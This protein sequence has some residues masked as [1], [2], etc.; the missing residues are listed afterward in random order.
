MP[1]NWI[2]LILALL[3]LIAAANA[4][5]LA[6]TDL[7]D[8]L[9]SWAP[10]VLD[11]IAGAGCPH[12]FNDGEARHCAW[13]G[14]LD[15]KAAAGGASFSQDWQAYRE[16]WVV[17]PGDELQWP[18]EVSIDGKPAAVLSRED[19]P[20]IKLA[21]GAHHITGRFQWKEM[22]ESLAL[23]ASIGLVRLDLN[24]RP[25]AQ[26]V[27]D[28]SNR[29]WLQRKQDAEGVEQAQ[30]RV[31]RKLID[32][33]PLML[34]TRISLEVSGKGRELTIDRALLPDLIPKELSSPLPA[35][36]AQDGNLKVQARAGAWELVLV[37]R[38]P[39]PVKT[40]ALP[41]SPGLAA[42]EEIWAFE[43]APLVRSVVIEGVPSVDPQQTTMPQEWRRLPAY[44][45]R[46]G[47]VLGLK[48]VRRGDSDPAPDKLTLERRLWLSF[49][50]DTLTMHDRMQ[51]EMHR[52]TRLTMNQAAQL[53]RVDVAGQDQLITRGSDGLAGI[54]VKRGK[55]NLSADSLAPG[56][57]RSFPAVGW[58]HDFDRMSMQLALPAGWRLLHAGGAD[59][60]DGAWLSRWNLLDFFL[61][62][63]IALA[64]SQL[65]SSGWGLIALAALVL[66]FQEPDAPRYAWLMPLAAVALLRVL[67]AGRF[68]TAVIWIGRI[69]MVA[70]LLIT[71][72]F[73]TAQIRGALYPVLEH[74]E[75]VNMESHVASAE[76]AAAVA[77]APTPA[78]APLARIVPEPAEAKARMKLSKS[79]E[80]SSLQSRYRSVD[81][82]AKVQTGP[83]LP[84]WRW[85]EYRL[86]WDGP[87][88]QDQQLDLWLISPGANKILV[89][90]RLAL[91]ALLLAHLAGM[92]LRPV[93]RGK[94]LRRLGK[95][96]AVL[97]LALSAALNPGSADAQ[98][99]DEKLLAEL[100][101][102]LLRPADCLPECAEISWLSVQ[103]AGSVLR[104][105]LEVDAAIDT[106]LPLP[107]GAKQWAPREARLDG[108]TAYVHRDEQG[109][110]WL[111]APAGKHRI[112]LNGELPA[113]DTLQLPLPRKPRRVEISAADWDVAG[114]SDDAAV[115]DT[116]QL[117][118]RL[119]AGAGSDAPA[120]PPFLRIERRLVLDLVWRVETTVRRDSPLGTP[121]LA[122]IPLLPGE[123]VTTPGIVVKE[124][125]VLINLAPQADSLS[126]SSTLKQ[127]SEIV[128]AAAR[129][130][131]WAESWILAAST[132]WHVSAE[133]LPSVAPDANQEA[134]LV[135]LP[136]PGETLKLKIERPQAVAGQT[137]TI[138]N[139]TLAARPGARV[140]EYQ[141][142]LVLRSSRGLDHNIT[143]P[144]GAIL[145]SVSINGQPRPIRANG[146]QVTLP[147]A[148]GKQSIE[149]VW[150][151]DQGMASSYSTLPAGL[152]L[153]SVNSRID[154]HVPRDRWLLLTSGPG[155]GPA[156]LF[157]G[158]LLIMLA[159]AF[160]LGR[161]AG[162]RLK[163]PHWLLLALGLT[164]VEW[165]ATVLVVGWFFALTMRGK[166]GN[167]DTPRWLFNL[168]QIGLAALT[169]AMLASLFSA[170]EGGLLGQPEMQ[171][172][173]NHSSAELLR[174][175]LDR[176]GPEVQ[177][178]W[179]FS[180]PVLAYRGLML[181][182][183][184]WLA[185][186]LL[187]WLKWGWS[188][189]GQGGWWRKK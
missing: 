36:L 133:G 69:S 48:E 146:R 188:V 49:D 111:L 104:L 38:H 162:L 40:L 30:L 189:F 96:M 122:Q 181:A 105:G 31:H 126:W 13:P 141:L 25:A 118:R 37:A 136:W 39:G 157:W 17:L 83:G 22:P 163:T 78:A 120:L 77:E 124:G 33:V 92:P 79:D 98:L 113:G 63:V 47:S 8:P 151:V 16:T 140:T 173:G 112:E 19:Q 95:G 14:V 86:G 50:G 166:N 183:A 7:P 76:G 99:P 152:N 59:R 134:D 116:L 23:P 148:P 27:R 169:V 64:V 5:P 132:I 186:S 11:G 182:W 144:P 164:Q 46:A 107:G 121:A 68:E 125:K 119:K 153:A 75:T 165:W 67:P 18:Q 131:A 60:A 15:V 176:A 74:V 159:A 101:E 34:E 128:L 24:G 147:I 171:I 32:G 43:A 85:H 72:S 42:E 45:M 41:A 94:G 150:N 155:I 10:W 135:F 185:W 103:A 97:L 180:L 28:E 12:L 44:L 3:C 80:P 156:I 65:W 184:L 161:F 35:V 89:L 143:L 51:G 61:V 130:T 70:L 102:K 142:S 174:W 100:K 177:Q 88:R 91:L 56:A 82:D 123:S 115:A 73:A 114:L 106:A 154:L 84:D 170:V 175:Y 158:K 160:A 4:A 53:G 137:L 21:P 87:V 2:S 9:K 6:R 20:S 109:G 179:I 110:L 29:L 81:P 93:G 62:L 90:L 167:A 1:K 58:K 117:T 52:A 168:R 127:G 129:E 26:A 54:E 139:S 187:A 108:K 55:L 145:K 57:P 138:D 149:L 172:A 178:A 66:S 71:L